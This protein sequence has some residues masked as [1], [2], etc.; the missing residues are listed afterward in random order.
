M[1]YLSRD[2]QKLINESTYIAYNTENGF[3]LLESMH[4]D[5][6]RKTVKEMTQYLMERYSEEE[7]YMLTEEEILNEFF[8]LL[9][10]RLQND[11]ALQNQLGKLAAARSVASYHEKMG[12][13]EQGRKIRQGE[14]F[15]SDVLNDL[16][17]EKGIKGFITRHSDAI[18]KWRM[19]RRK[20]ALDSLEAEKPNPTKSDDF[21]TIKNVS[22]DILKKKYGEKFEG[23]K[24]SKVEKTTKDTSSDDKAKESK[25]T[26]TRDSSEDKTKGLKQEI[27]DKAKKSSVQPRKISRPKSGGRER[28]VK[29]DNTKR[30]S[31]EEIKKSIE[32]RKNDPDE[33]KLSKIRKNLV[34]SDDEEWKKDNK[35][36]KRNTKKRSKRIRQRSGRRGR[37]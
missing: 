35:N 5:Q 15:G 24:G 18:A 37:R 20:A 34:K 30:R 28:P 33:V 4:E 25:E 27:T 8:S 26:T 3:M 22:R 32:N 12:N 9:G 7:L 6:Y 23:L 21:K 13:K 29:A 17:S 11:K 10:K 31:S 36:K 16:R 1:S 2:E 14:D 19:N